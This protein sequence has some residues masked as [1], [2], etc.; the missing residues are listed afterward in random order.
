MAK[1]RGCSKSVTGGVRAGE[2]EGPSIRSLLD[3]PVEVLDYVLEDLSVIDLR[4][5]SSVSHM[6][7]LESCSSHPFSDKFLSCRRPTKKLHLA[8]R[9][10]RYTRDH[11]HAPPKLRSG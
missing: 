1:I 2:V 8:Q 5:L 9:A 11:S 10:C 7:F 4:S 6:G 3:L